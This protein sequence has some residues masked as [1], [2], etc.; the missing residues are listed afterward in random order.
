MEPAGA[1]RLRKGKLGG[2]RLIR[3]GGQGV[4]AAFSSQ[5][6]QARADPFAFLRSVGLLAF[7][8]WGAGVIRGLRRIG[9]FGFKRLDARGQELNL[10]PERLDQGVLLGVAQVGEGRW[11][12]YL[13][14]RI[15]S[16]ATLSRKMSSSQRKSHAVLAGLDGVD[17]EGDE[18]LP[19]TRT[20]IF[21]DLGW[22]A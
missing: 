13:A 20:I 18:Q 8:W 17:G 21:V 2:H 1:P 22:H 16:S 3:I 7:R 15:E 10:R 11:R 9:R 4:A 6:T 12:G 14:V 5:A 19:G